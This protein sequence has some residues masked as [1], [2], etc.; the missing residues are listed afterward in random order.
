M[1]GTVVGTKD[2]GVNCKAK[3]T[4][5]GMHSVNMNGIKNEQKVVTSDHNHYLPTSDSFQQPRATSEPKKKK[6][7]L[8][9]TPF[10]HVE[11][12][13]E[14]HLE[15]QVE[16]HVEMQVET[17]VETYVET[18]MVTHLEMHVE[19][20]VKNQNRQKHQNW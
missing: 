17:Q 20:H 13:M 1:P 6:L 5:S 4:D 16:T 10:I 14:T 7:I 19:T 2:K 12:H 15:T 11:T 9:H 8:E 3:M 18:H